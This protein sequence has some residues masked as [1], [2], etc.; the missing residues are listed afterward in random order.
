MK[1]LLLLL[2]LAPPLQ[3]QQRIPPP[4]VA[5]SLWQA[6]RECSGAPVQP[7]GDLSDVV[8]MVDSVAAHDRFHGSRASWSPPDTIR[9][10]VDL[11]YVNVPWVIAH[12]LLHHL[13]RGPPHAVHPLNP[14]LFPCK[15]MPLQ[16]ERIP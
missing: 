6:I 11:D 14:F 10:D 8:W 16:H 13:L 4:G 2:V 5:D 7:G 1:W 3:A 9:F 15:L 12:E